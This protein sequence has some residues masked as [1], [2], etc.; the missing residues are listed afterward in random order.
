MVSSLTPIAA[1]N[2]HNA[3]EKI[4]FEQELVVAYTC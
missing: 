3:K 4:N 1:I 2:I